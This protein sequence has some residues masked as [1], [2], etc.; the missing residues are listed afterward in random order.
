MDTHVATLAGTRRTFSLATMAATLDRLVAEHPSAGVPVV[1]PIATAVSEFGATIVDGAAKVRIEAQHATL[2]AAGVKVDATSQLYATGTRMA[3]IGYDTQAGRK[4]EHDAAQP[5][6]LAVRGLVGRIEAEGRADVEVTASELAPT[7]TVN[8]AAKC[9]GGLKLSEQS[10]RGLLG[11]LESPAL[12]YVL[13]VRSRIVAELAKG[14]D[15]D[16]AI[17]ADDKRELAAVLQHECRRY[18][19]TK[20]KLRTRRNVGDV[21]AVVSPSYSPADAPEVL[22]DVMATM[23]DDAKGSY[24]YDPTTTSWELRANIWTPTPVAEQAVGEAFEGFVSF[25]SSDNGTGRLT[26]GGGVLLLACLN[27][28][29]YVANGATVSRVHRGAILVDVAA[30]M[31][32]AM[33]A[34]DAL[35]E[36]WGRARKEVV[37]KAEG[38][39]SEELVGMP[40]S[41]AIKG[42]WWGE[43]GAPKRELAGLLPGRTRDHVEGLTAAY[44]DERRNPR[45][46]TRADM[47]Q[48]WTRYIQGQPTAAR[49]EA[50][51]AIGSWLV[52]PQPLRYDGRDD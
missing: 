31:S 44:L 19:S 33:G 47:A 9:L 12:S 22:R 49:R 14:D 2:I 38:I 48:G 46:L 11:R 5:L 40:I 52:N 34:I 10:I 51:Q 35:C 23:A 50:E 18:G 13:G 26:G 29:T 4:A 45:D 17:V 28:S 20:L 41:Q 3:Q 32:G 30:M 42:L 8:G 24:A 7:I 36:A 43:L 15:A 39:A 27:A 1:E 21:F 25:R 16:R 37:T 6:A